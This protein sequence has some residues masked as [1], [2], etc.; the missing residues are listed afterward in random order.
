[1]NQSKMELMRNVALFLWKVEDGK[2]VSIA[3]V[4]DGVDV[5]KQGGIEAL[6]KLR[7]D[8]LDSD[9]V[10]GPGGV[11]AMEVEHAQLDTELKQASLEVAKLDHDGAK[12]DR[13]Q[14]KAHIE[15]MK[16]VSPI[17]GYVER[18]LLR[19]GES[20]DQAKEVILLIQTDPLWVESVH[21]HGQGAAAGG[22][23]EGQRA[24]PA[25][26]GGR[27]HA[28]QAEQAIGKI[29]FK[30]SMTNQAGQLMVRVE[31][32]NPNNRPAGEPVRVQFDALSRLSAM[33]AHQASPFNP[34]ARPAVQM[35]ASTPAKSQQV[36]PVNA[37]KANTPAAKPGA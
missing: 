4:K 7:G 5:L 20:S 19:K 9:E 27:L 26:C 22:G 35:R 17:N 33:D 3:K 36:Q 29:V 2:H 30:S 18:L 34:S 14:M 25:G 31:V 8:N 10:A 24:V 37:P 12:A 28:A 21:P 1:M 13:D 32:P 6:A 15:Q 16:I 23:A 11:S